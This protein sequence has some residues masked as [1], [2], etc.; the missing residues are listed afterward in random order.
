MMHRTN[1]VSYEVEQAT[2]ELKKIA[3]CLEVLV[4]A[5]GGGGNGCTL[6]GSIHCE[7]T[8]EAVKES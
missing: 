1:A 8:E 7:Q 6:R 3:A 4:A 2:V 5:I